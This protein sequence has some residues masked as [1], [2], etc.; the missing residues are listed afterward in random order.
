[1]S[2]GE[3]FQYKSSIGSPEVMR[4]H[5]TAPT[6]IRKAQTARLPLLL[7]IKPNHQDTR[8][9]REPKARDS[10]NC[11][12]ISSCLGVLVVKGPEEVLGYA[13]VHIV[14]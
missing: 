2:S 10:A 7:L 8:A 6:R 5:F 9:P 14:A 11:P 3:Q 1:M 4:F 12:M 13:C